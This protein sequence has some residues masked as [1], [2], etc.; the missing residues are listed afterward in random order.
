MPNILEHLMN[1]QVD[2]FHF[3][4]MHC[5]IYQT[6]PCYCVKLS[7]WVTT[8][9]KPKVGFITARKGSVLNNLLTMAFKGLQPPQQ[10]EPETL[11]HLH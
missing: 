2:S 8:Q 4:S 11:H 5:G 9:R 3:T 7:L 1:L 6:H 10:Q